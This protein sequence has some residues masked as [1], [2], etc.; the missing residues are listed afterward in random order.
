MEMRHLEDVQLVD[1]F[2]GRWTPDQERSVELHL[3]ECDHCSSLAGRLFA[4]AQF[5]DQW[6]VE[7]QR[8]VIP[9]TA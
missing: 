7:R 4:N 3:A 9:E 6:N 8:E 1:Y 2:S 5:F